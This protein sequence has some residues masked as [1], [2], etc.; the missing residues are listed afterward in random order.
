MDSRLATVDAVVLPHGPNRRATITKEPLLHD[1]ELFTR[2]NLQTGATLVRKALRP[3]SNFVAG[4]SRQLA[5]GLTRGPQQTSDMR[6][7]AIAKGVQ[8]QMELF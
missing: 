2:P 5:G 4:P 7:R 8:D 1:D 3:H 6:L